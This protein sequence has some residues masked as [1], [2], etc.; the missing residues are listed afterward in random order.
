MI[1]SN[2]TGKAA[3]RCLTS[4]RRTGWAR[5]AAFARAIA[6]V[7]GV[8]VLA[9]VACSTTGCYRTQNIVRMEPLDTKVPVSASGQYVNT[10]GRIVK[11][12]EYRIVS[13]FSFERTVEVPRHKKAEADLDLDLE[14]EID[15]IVVEAGGDAVTD[16]KIEGTEYDSGAHNAAASW[17]NMGW[18]FGISGAAFIVTGLAIGDPDINAIFL[19]M[20]GVFAGVGAVSFGLSFT[21]RKPAAWHFNVAGNVVSHGGGSTPPAPTAPSPAD[22]ATPNDGS[23][24][25]AAPRLVPRAAEDEAI[26]PLSP[27]E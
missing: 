7:R 12:T 8:A 3:F 14:S 2:H 13:D 18:A 21:A 4:V 16:F 6:V 1:E 10:E 22:E 17:K 24:A 15:R 23:P 19:P 27:A 5:G 26:E 20:G 11:E 25:P 9:L